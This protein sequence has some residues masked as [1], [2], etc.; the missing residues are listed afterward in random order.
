[1]IV[2]NKFIKV[3]KVISKRYI[4]FYSINYFFNLPLINVYINRVKNKL[5]KLIN[6][7]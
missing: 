6:N 7:I 2:P 1:M 4:K 3:P 5:K